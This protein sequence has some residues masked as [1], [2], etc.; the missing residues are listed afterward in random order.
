M[1]A[2]PGFLEDLFAVQLACDAQVCFKNAVVKGEQYA[3]VDFFLTEPLNDI[4][5]QLD[6]V[7]QPAAYLVDGI[8]R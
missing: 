3:T 1:S 6:D 8:R 4:C 2:C 7:T 5:V